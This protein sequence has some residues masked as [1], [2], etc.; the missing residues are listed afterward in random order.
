[1]K[2]A[3]SGTMNVVSSIMGSLGENNGGDGICG[4]NG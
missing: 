3:L 2:V 4:W 1:M